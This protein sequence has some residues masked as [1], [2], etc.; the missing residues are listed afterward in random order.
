MPSALIF[1]LAALCNVA[2]PADPYM[3]RGSDN[4]TVY[5]NGC[6]VAMNEHLIAVGCHNNTQRSVTLFSAKN[7]H[8]VKTFYPPQGSGTKR[9]ER[10]G[11][12]LAMNELFLVVGSPHSR[13]GSGNVYVYTIKNLQ[14]QRQQ[15]QQQQ[16]K[17]QQQQRQQQ[18]PDVTLQPLDG[19]EYYNMA[20]PLFGWTVS[21]STRNEIVV[22]SPDGI[23][24]DNL[25]YLGMSL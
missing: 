14:N 21:I 11:T 5:M 4:K 2:R 23:H 25:V 9:N 13:N 10:F 24:Y 20:G 18:Q 6:S 16:R 12:S 8:V 17:Q 19:D 22:G 3:F 7:L 15:Q 1:L